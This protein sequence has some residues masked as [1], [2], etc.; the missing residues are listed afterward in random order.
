MQC[1]FCHKDSSA[2]KCTEHIIPVS[3][4]NKHYTKKIYIKKLNK[5]C[6]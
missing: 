3:I 6:I 4:G 1:I 5:L 2:S